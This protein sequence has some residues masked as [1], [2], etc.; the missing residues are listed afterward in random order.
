[1]EK[2]QFFNTSTFTA[3]NNDDNGK[4][5]KFQQKT[6]PILQAKC[7]LRLHLFVVMTF[8]VTKSSYWQKKLTKEQLKLNY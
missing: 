7:F 1:M 8:S 3:L 6:R 5:N 2:A 4:T